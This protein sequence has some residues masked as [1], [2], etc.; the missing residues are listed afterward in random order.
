MK[1]HT[2]PAVFQHLVH[3]LV[4]ARDQETIAGDLLEAYAERCDRGSLAADLWYLRNAVSLAP[5]AAARAYVAA[6][7]LVLLCCFSAL[8]AAW[9][10]T[11][12]LLLRHGNLLQQESIAGLIFGQ[13]MLTLIMLPLRRLRWLR[14]AAAL[15]AAAISWLGGSAFLA[16]ARGDHSFE[17]YIL[18][19]SLLLIIQAGMT[20]SHLLRKRTSIA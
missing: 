13:A 12:S 3:A 20:W 6:P 11:M 2:P 16:V 1:R 19:I 17:G 14:W 7:A 9:L 10:G 4:A 8:C 18:L 5:R 15:G